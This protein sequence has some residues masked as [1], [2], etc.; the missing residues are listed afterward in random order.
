LLAKSPELLRQDQDQDQ[1][2]IFTRD[3]KY[4]NRVL[5]ITESSVRLCVRLS[6][7]LSATLRLYQ[8]DAS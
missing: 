7:R 5:A 2:F 1:D 6:V 4:A 8:N 3:S